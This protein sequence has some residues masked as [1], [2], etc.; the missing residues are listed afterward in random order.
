MRSPIPFL[1]AHSYELLVTAVVLALGIAS[2]QLRLHRQGDPSVCGA[3]Q[4]T[5]LPASAP[6]ETPA[7]ASAPD[8]LRPVTGG[9]LTAYAGDVPCWNA[10]MDCWQI[11]AGVDLAASPGETVRAAAD[12]AVLRV[13]TDPLMGLTV[14]IAHADGMET[15]YA[16]LASAACAPGD[17]LCRGDA[18]GIAGDSADAESLLGCHLHFELLQHDVPVKPVFAP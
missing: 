13:E 2:R 18:V 5:A 1:K 12:G 7:P 3:P 11:H 15:R 9:I 16:A 8:W 10:G 4:P 14:C 17:V 6:A